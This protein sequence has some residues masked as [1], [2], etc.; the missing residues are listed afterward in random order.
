M[1]TPVPQAILTTL[2][3]DGSKGPIFYSVTRARVL[4]SGESVYKIFSPKE[5]T[6]EFL[7]EIFLGK[8]NWIYR[9]VWQAYPRLDPIEE[10]A[11]IVLYPNDTET[12][13]VYYTSGIESFISTMETSALSGRNVAALLSNRLWEAQIPYSITT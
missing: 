1:T 2:P 11:P 5:I 13:G 6:D 10:F 4:P 12:L 7:S 9:K 3:L 8:I